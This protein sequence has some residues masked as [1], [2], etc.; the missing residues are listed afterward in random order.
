M[1]GRSVMRAAALALVAVLAAATAAGAQQW[2]TGTVSIVVPFGPGSTPDIAARILAERLQARLGQSFVVENKTG[3]SGN[4][5]TAA[6]AKARPDGS[7]IGIS[8]VGPLALNTLLFPQLPYD[9]A[10][11]LVPVTMVASQP[12]VL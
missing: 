4:I 6:V 5:G 9:P 10:K 12:S 1:P 3:A 7:T 2:P 8:I 11:D